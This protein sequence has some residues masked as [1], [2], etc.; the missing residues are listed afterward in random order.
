MVTIINKAADFRQN[1]NHYVPP[2]DGALI[3]AFVGN[4][5][6]NIALR[7]FG[8][9]NDMSVIG[10]M[11]VTSGGD[12][13]RA[14][15]NV[16]HMISAAARPAGNCT[17][18]AVFS[19]PAAA[20]TWCIPMSSERNI[21]GGGRRG[22][23]LGQNNSG[24][25]RVLFQMNGTNTS[26]GHLIVNSDVFI[27]AVP[28]KV[29]TGVYTLS[30]GT[31]S[32]QIFDETTPAAGAVS[33]NTST[34]LQ[35]AANEADFPFLIGANPLGTVTSGLIGFVGLWPFALSAAQ[36]AAQVASLRRYFAAFGVTV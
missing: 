6:P 14:F 23:T 11:P 1:F 18:M 15:T 16:N 22:L 25:G 26:S 30:G 29:V 19:Q 3:C 35:A 17:L 36:R 32:A 28:A 8:T 34:T 12:C 33:S 5:D 27:T 13:F 9:A 24:T 31:S 2:V 4:A 21:A 7:N 10:N 20:T